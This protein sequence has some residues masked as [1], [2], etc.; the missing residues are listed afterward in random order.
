MTYVALTEAITSCTQL[1]VTYDNATSKRPTGYSL[2][3]KRG[4]LN[5][6]RLSRLNVVASTLA[7]DCVVGV[8]CA[9][10]STDA[11]APHAKIMPGSRGQR[12]AMRLA[13]G[14]RR[15]AQETMDGATSTKLR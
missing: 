8:T 1:V 11:R 9:A 2:R 6:H 10:W 13:I 12:R 7:I 4:Q 3:R 14:S 15:N 5:D